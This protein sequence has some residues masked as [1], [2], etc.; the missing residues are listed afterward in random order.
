MRKTMTTL[1]MGVVAAVFLTACAST[2]GSGG[3]EGAGAAGGAGGAASGAEAYPAGGSG[4]VQGQGLA[5]QAGLL[6]KRTIY[7]AFDK[8]TVKPE[9]RDII[10]AHAAYLSAHPKL[11]VTLEGNTDERG[12]R[13]YNIGLGERRAEA[14]KQ[15]LLVQG[16]AAN[17]VHT[18]SYGEE[19][20]VCTA[21]D[22][23]CWRL[24]RRVDIVYSGQ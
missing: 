5:G 9:Y 10:A 13:E 2:G 20:P 3:Q 7:F 14:V 15:M 24:N 18:I 12:S 8:S 6:A 1:L 11:T 23:S 4:G 17:Q 21:H 22:E 16:V 19:R